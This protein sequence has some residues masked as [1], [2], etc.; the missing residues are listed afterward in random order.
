M[1]KATVLI[2]ADEET[3]GKQLVEDLRNALGDQG[4]KYRAVVGPFKFDGPGIGDPYVEI[5]VRVKSLEPLP[6]VTF[7]PWE[8]EDH[9][10]R[11]AGSYDLATPAGRARALAVLEAATNLISSME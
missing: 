1:A 7:M 8:A 9:V 6:R 2:T 11:V 10:K 4:I 3:L 5:G